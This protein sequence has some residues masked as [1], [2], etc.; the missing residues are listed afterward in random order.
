MELSSCGS[1]VLETAQ[2]EFLALEN[3][4]G[5]PTL[6]A[7]TDM[8]SLGCVFASLASNEPLFARGDSPAITIKSIFEIIGLPGASV[9]DGFKSMPRWSDDFLAVQ[10][11]G[12]QGHRRFADFVNCVKGLAGCVSSFRENQ[13]CDRTL[14]EF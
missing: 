2:R 9:L 14:C 5:A 6:A 4:F 3:L 11:K 10:I 12:S 7:H 8:W 1:E 13:V